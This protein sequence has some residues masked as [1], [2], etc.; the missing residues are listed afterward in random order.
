MITKSVKWRLERLVLTMQSE[1]KAGDQ[2]E[3][4]K[5]KRDQDENEKRELEKI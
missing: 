1:K 4:K 5:G 2:R 3:S